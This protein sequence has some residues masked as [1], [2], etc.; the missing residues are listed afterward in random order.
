MKKREVKTTAERCSVKFAA[1]KK[2]F[3]ELNDQNV[4]GEKGRRVQWPFFSKMNELLGLSDASTLKHVHGVGADSSKM[5]DDDSNP[6][7]PPPPKKSRA[8]QAGITHPESISR[9]IEI[10]RSPMD[11]EFLKEIRASNAAS[12]TKTE[13]IVSAS[14]AFE[15]LKMG[16]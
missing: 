4:D 12:L 8:R 9:L 7:T 15:K 16:Y 5:R 14:K 10:D 13:D 11:Q 6:S 3:N 1:M 2:N